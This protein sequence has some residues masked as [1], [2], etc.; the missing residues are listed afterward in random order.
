MTKTHAKFLMV[1]FG[2]IILSSLL[3]SA[4]S[5][6][7]AYE[8]VLDNSENVENSF[9][10]YDQY[11]KFR[12][13]IVED[14]EFVIFIEIINPA[15]IDAFDIS[16]T[17]FLRN[18][19][20][21]KQSL[22][23][24]GSLNG[25]AEF[26]G[27][28]E[29]LFNTED[30]PFLREVASYEFFSNVDLIDG[31]KLEIPIGG[32]YDFYITFEIIETD[33][34]SENEGKPGLFLDEIG[35]YL[36][37]ILVVVLIL[38]VFFIVMQMKG[39][40]SNNQNGAIVKKPSET[41]KYSPT[42][43]SELVVMEQVEQIDEYEDNEDEFCGNE[44]WQLDPDFHVECAGEFF[45]GLCPEERDFLVN[46]SNL[47]RCS[48]CGEFVTKLE[49]GGMCYLCSKSGNHS[50]IRGSSYNARENLESELVCSD[51]F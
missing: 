1:A 47:K 34:K 30:L 3:V 24:W 48:C 9:E 44:D 22:C 46:R 42:D 13:D 45:R 50:R 20:E 17:Y 18:G 32:I 11:I 41:Y 40:K 10:I 21:F 5:P 6:C 29:F 51:E 37:G 12:F 33:E 7:S 25:I 4:F 28:T 8:N 19:S 39:G 31:E 14:P 35:K 16:V 2:V 23:Q 36:I 26:H 43:E 38:P 27:E 15:S 49:K